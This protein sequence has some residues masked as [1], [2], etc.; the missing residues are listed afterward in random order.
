MYHTKLMLGEWT[1]QANN[2]DLAVKLIDMP[3]NLS[4]L[5]ANMQ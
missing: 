3:T 2:A 1:M 5:I 4:D